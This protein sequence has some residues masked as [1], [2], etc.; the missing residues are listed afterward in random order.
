MYVWQRSTCLYLLILLHLH[1]LWVLQLIFKT[2][3]CIFQL[4][5]SGS[6]LLKFSCQRIQTWVRCCQS[7][8]AFT[9]LCWFSFFSLKQLFCTTEILL[10]WRIPC[11]ALVQFLIHFRQPFWQCILSL[12]LQKKLKSQQ[13]N[14]LLSWR[15]PSREWMAPKK[16]QKKTNTV[17]STGFCWKSKK[18]LGYLVAE[19]LNVLRWPHSCS[20]FP[21]FSCVL[22]WKCNVMFLV[23]KN[24]GKKNWGHCVAS[25]K[26]IKDSVK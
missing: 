10:Q 12:F 23:C 8:H 3:Q 17:Q 21:V 25:I 20:Q 7:F 4:R 24:T 5:N 26:Q 18:Q 19:N 1:L 13:L 16:R 15:Y 22:H 6:C 2:I 11:L 9:Q 14:N